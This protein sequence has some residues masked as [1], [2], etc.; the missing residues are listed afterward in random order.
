MK[1]IIL[2]MTMAL[3]LTVLAQAQT[4]QARPHKTP[5]ERAAHMTTMLQKKLSLNEAQSVKVKSILLARATE[6]QNLKAKKGTDKKS[7]REAFTAQLQKTDKE[8]SSVFT[9][10]QNKAYGEIKAKMKANHH[11]GGKFT[12]QNRKGFAKNP[13]KRAE[14]MTGMLKQKLNLNDDQSAKVKAIF[15]ARAAQMESLRAKQPADKKF[16]RSAFKALKQ[17]TDKEL[18][19]VLT[20]DQNKTYGEMKAKMK[21]RH[22]AKKDVMA[23]TEG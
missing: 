10:D 7:N 17:S 2:M 20:A 18:A 13:E 19:S 6:M 23:P 12:A 14:R 15:V 5:E 22:K 9:A 8:L 1:K 3:G 16:D 21:D 11:K 4:K